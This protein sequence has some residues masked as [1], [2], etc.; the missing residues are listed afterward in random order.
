MD[1]ERS[2]DCERDP[3]STYD[4]VIEVQRVTSMLDDAYA[5][6][7]FSALTAGEKT[8]LRTVTEVGGYGAC[9]VSDAFERF[10][11]RVMDH[12]RRQD[13]AT[14]M[15]IYLERDGTYYGPYI[16]QSDQVIAA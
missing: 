16:E 9:E 6:I 15:A 14:E 8:V 5:P 12:W 7:H 11:D 4:S 1:W 10:V 2:T 3:D 13:D